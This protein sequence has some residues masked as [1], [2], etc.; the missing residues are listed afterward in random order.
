MATNSSKLTVGI[1]YGLL[2]GPTHGRYFRSQ[3]A[4]HGFRYSDD[5]KKCDIIVAHSA[6]CW[7]L[8]PDVQPKI[9]LYVAMPLVSER[10]TRTF[11]HANWRNLKHLSWHRISKTAVAGIGYG[12]SQPKRN[13]AIVRGAKQATPTI[14]KTG[15]KILVINQHDPWPRGLGLRHYIKTH[16]WAF[17]SL[18]GSHDDVWEHPKRYIK[19]LERYARLLA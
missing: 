2:E 14:P 12:L 10:L 18:P 6:G 15:Q 16:P 4:K 13:I 19:L 9:L 1:S 17:V 11:L 8:S 3:L 5:H 7:L